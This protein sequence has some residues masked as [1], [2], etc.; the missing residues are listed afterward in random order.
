MA[1]PAELA[2]PKAMQAIWDASA[3][4]KVDSQ[5]DA[6]F[7]PFKDAL[8]NAARA[9]DPEVWREGGEVVREMPCGCFDVGDHL[10]LA[11]D[12]QTLV[13]HGADG[14]RQTLS[15]YDIKSGTV[16][17]LL[18]GHRRDIRSVV[19]RGDLIVSGDGAGQILLWALGSGQQTGALQA[20][21][22]RAH[23][24]DVFG[25]AI[26]GSLL[27]SGAHDNTIKLWNLESKANTATLREHTGGI[28]GVAL[29]GDGAVVSAGQDR[30][31][32]VWP[33]PAGTEQT[34]QSTNTFQHPAKVYSIDAEGDTVA[35]A[36]MDS[37]VRTFSRSA[38]GLTR[39]FTAHRSWAN[40]VRIL[41]N[42][43]V[44]GS[45]DATVKVWSLAT[46]QGELIASLEAH[47]NMVLG[48]AISPTLGYVCSMGQDGKLFVWVP[49]SSQQ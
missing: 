43:L 38:N 21:G 20:V 2:R 10:A 31:A 25:L 48:L 41:G 36:C 5:A 34:V 13:G 35:T 1:V 24:A 42:L 45:T 49:A 22:G 18:R 6:P 7:M 47:N 40:T 4:D 32:K 44:S 9:A 27:V 37:V 17:K 14:Q 30:L 15:V 16:L 39:T 3:N 28:N 29:T 23:N 11:A 19:V 26:D 33:L 8:D 46:A 12:G